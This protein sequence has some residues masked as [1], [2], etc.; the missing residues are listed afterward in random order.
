VPGLSLV[1]IRE[2][3]HEILSG[4]DA[5]RAQFF[6]AFDAFLSGPEA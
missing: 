1:E 5:I 4:P 6:A 2:A 3:R